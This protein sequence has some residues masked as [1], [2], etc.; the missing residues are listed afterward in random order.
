M[1]S[2]RTVNNIVTSLRVVTLVLQP[3]GQRSTGKWSQISAWSNSSSWNID[4]PQNRHWISRLPHSKFTCVF[5]WLRKIVVRQLFG[6]LLTIL[7][8]RLDDGVDISCLDSQSLCTHKSP[9]G[10]AVAATY[11]YRVDQKSKL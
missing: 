6:Q 8:F 3:R 4:P 2:M 11:S 1:L 10:P 9:R 7:K 5:S